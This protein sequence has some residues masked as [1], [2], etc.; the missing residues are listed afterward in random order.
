MKN[1]IKTTITLLS[2]VL[3]NAC[4]DTNIVD[5]TVMLDIGWKNLKPHIIELN[6]YNQNECVRGC[7]F[8]SDYYYKLV[9]ESNDHGTFLT[10]K[11]YSLSKEDIDWYVW[12]RYDKDLYSLIDAIT[13][14]LR[15]ESPILGYLCFVWPRAD[16]I[17][18]KPTRILAL[19]KKECD[20]W[21]KEHAGYY[22]E[23]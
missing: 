12:I 8:C 17:A 13:E 14:N 6:G 22:T 20:E 18:L 5:N 7:Y 19:T 11:A 1:W 16:F 10:K 23:L 9:F 2:L 15:K 21:I 4:Q 3:L